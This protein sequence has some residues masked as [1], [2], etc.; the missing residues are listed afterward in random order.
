MSEETAPHIEPTTAVDL[1]TFKENIVQ[2]KSFLSKL[3]EKEHELEQSYADYIAKKAALDAIV[4][5]FSSYDESRK[6]Y[7]DAADQTLEQLE[8][9][10]VSASSLLSQATDA[11]KA[12]SAFKIKAESD[13]ETLEAA[14]VRF[15][16]LK[17]AANELAS[18]LDSKNTDIQ[19]SITKIDADLADFEKKSEQITSFETSASEA[20]SRLQTIENEITSQRDNAQSSLNET[21]NVLNELVSQQAAVAGKIQEIEGK[22]EE[23][24]TAYESLLIGN[25]DPLLGPVEE[26]VR[27]QI[28]ELL[29]SIKADRD[30]YQASHLD[31][32]NTLQANHDERINILQNL[33][34][35]KM[36]TLQ[37]FHEETTARFQNLYDELKHK[38]DSLLPGAGAAGLASSYYQAKMRYATNN[39]IKLTNDSSDITNR[40]KLTNAD[41]APQWVAYAFNLLLFLIP[42]GALFYTF[43]DFHYPPMFEKE[44]F[45]ALLY[46]LT[47]TLP[48]VAVS[49]YGI[50]S[51][52]SDK[53]MYEAYNHKQR[54]MQLYHSFKTEID[55]S[56]DP[57]LKSKL[58]DVMLD[59]VKDKPDY[60]PNKTDRTI[61]RLLDTLQKPID[62]IADKVLGS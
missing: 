56:N 36:N 60:K 47:L 54:V 45:A 27:T 30:S 18:Q 1:A 8:Q 28:E 11:E 43:L 52:V 49:T 14:K 29:A 42:L 61:A 48:L 15:S 20:Y 4:T 12:I 55:Q 25:D 13:I 10:S 33:S 37:T 24:S 46:K 34:T 44:P 21:T 17:D 19:S 31:K 41:F 23:I 35:E 9:S 39:D 58:L 57:V 16:D 53:K 32:L 50:V 26:S 5:S 3:H 40:I 7:S 59:V 38:I 22:F 62:K 6:A 2:F 51:L